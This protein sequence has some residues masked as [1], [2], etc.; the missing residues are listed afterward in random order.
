MLGKGVMFGTPVGE[1]QRGGGQIIKIL[2]TIF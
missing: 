1:K 2:L